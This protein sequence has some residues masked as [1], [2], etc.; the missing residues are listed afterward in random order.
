VSQCTT[1]KHIY[2]EQT[3]ERTRE[4][5]REREREENL[6]SRGKEDKSTENGISLSI[7]HHGNDRHVLRDQGVASDVLRRP[8][9]AG[10][11]E[12]AAVEVGNEDGRGERRGDDGG[13][14]K[15]S[16]GRTEDTKIRKLSGF[17]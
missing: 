1:Y 5:E 16:Q 7:A 15:G 8:H 17:F 13:A 2:K 14:R 6:F 3:R 12:A 11:V 10:R 9:A 4:R